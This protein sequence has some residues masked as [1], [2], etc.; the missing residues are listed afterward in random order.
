M[1]RYQR[2]RLR[3]K[4]LI[5]LLD[6]HEVKALLSRM[7]IRFGFC[8]PPVEIEKLSANPPKS[9]DEFTVAALIAEGY[10]YT[11]SDPLCVQARD[12]VAQAFAEHLEK[13]DR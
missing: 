3:T 9:I 4:H 12:V 13:L 11:K 6:P 5:V 10:G 2:E 1:S 8:L 7:C